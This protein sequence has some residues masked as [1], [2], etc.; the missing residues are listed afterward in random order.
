MACKIALVDFDGTLA[1]SM[2]SWLALP[3]ELIREEGLP[4]P[5]GLYE[6]IRTRPMWEL[7]EYFASVRR[8]A[9]TA[10]DVRRLW[11]ERM[12][13]RY[14]HEVSLKDGAVGFLA[15]LRECGARVVLFSAT[16]RH[17]LLPAAEHF[18]LLPYFDGVI[19]EAEVGAKHDAETYRAL[20][21]HYG[22]GLSDMLL[23]EDS[24]VNLRTAGALGLSTV[25]VYEET[26]RDWW[27]ALSAEA[28]VSLPSFA[29]LEA[30]R[31]LLS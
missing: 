6:R 1:D 23:A 16:R 26:R 3:A 18:G 30:L 22:C 21:A 14:L 12:L 5:E 10:E 15:L 7:A 24:A 9:S 29:D 27:Q 4:E 8:P 28:D 11:E 19:T 13:V 31:A 20:A 17:L 25:A 2:P